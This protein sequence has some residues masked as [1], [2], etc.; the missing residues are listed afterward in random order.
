MKMFI[1]L[2]SVWVSRTN[3]R[4]EKRKGTW[5]GNLTREGGGRNLCDV[6]K[7]EHCLTGRGFMLGSRS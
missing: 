1:C 2:R 5:V 4:A 3:K 7:R 6:F